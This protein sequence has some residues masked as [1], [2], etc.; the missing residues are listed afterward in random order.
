MRRL[1]MRPQ[2]DNALLIIANRCAGRKRSTYQQ[3]ISLVRTQLGSNIH[4]EKT[5]YIGHAELLAYQAS[6]DSIQTVVAVGGD[7][8]VH[9]ILNGLLKNPRNQTALCCLPA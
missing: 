2:S 8:T 7:G 4:F 3:L 6:I 9:E 5:K 1:H